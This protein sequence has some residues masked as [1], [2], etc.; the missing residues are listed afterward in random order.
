MADLKYALY[1]E[2]AQQASCK[3]RHSIRITSMRKLILNGQ[4]ARKMCRLLQS[5]CLLRKGNLGIKQNA[6]TVMKMGMSGDNLV[7]SG[8]DPEIQKALRM[9][10]I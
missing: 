5:S 2:A 4:N 8:K 10:D 7:L 9:T 1:F 3:N 6:G